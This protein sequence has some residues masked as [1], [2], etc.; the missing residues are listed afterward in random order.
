MFS[1]MKKTVSLIKVKNHKNIDKIDKFLFFT[2]LKREL[3]NMRFVHPL[4]ARLFFFQVKSFSKITSYHTGIFLKLL[5][6]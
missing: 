2:L 5:I 1:V 6:V 4:Y 3:S